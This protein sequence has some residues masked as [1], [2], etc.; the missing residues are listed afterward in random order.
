[1]F[2]PCHA[3]QKVFEEFP[4]PPFGALDSHRCHVV[5]MLAPL[6]SSLV[7]LLVCVAFPQVL[8]LFC[9]ARCLPKGNVP[10]L[11]IP[12]YLNVSELSFQL[13]S[14]IPSSQVYCVIVSHVV[15]CIP[16]LCR[17]RPT[18]MQASSICYA[19]SGFHFSCMFFKTFVGQINYV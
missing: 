6:F 18:S 3:G 1:M 2:Q 9:F 15:R 12:K 5:P 17:H 14:L 7:V 19:M 13:R 4:S 8:N 16:P 10:V 11:T